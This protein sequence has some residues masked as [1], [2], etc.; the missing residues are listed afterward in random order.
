M[1][2]RFSRLI[3]IKRLTAAA[4]ALCFSAG[5]LAQGPPAQP[6]GQAAAQ[7]QRP[8]SPADTASTLVGGEWVKNAQG[9]L[10]YQGGKWIEVIYSR[11][12]L[13]QREKIFG[14]GADYGKAVIAGAPM[15]RVG[16]NATRYN[17]D[18]K[19]SLWG[20][21]GYTP[22]KDVLRVPM[23]TDSSGLLWPS[24]DQLTIFFCDVKK[25]SGKMVITWDKTVA[26]ADFTAG[27]PGL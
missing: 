5:L 9:N 20:S 4:G 1:R 17:A 2:A 12:M 8:L 11:P 7:R 27:K 13:R 18:D 23:Q 24:I 3:S 15:W 22:D 16:A 19:T 10:V 14:S 21:Y 6:P 25:D 26:L